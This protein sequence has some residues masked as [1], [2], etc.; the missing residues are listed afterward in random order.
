MA[1]TYRDTLSENRDKI[2]FRIGDTQ[3]NEGPRP[4][5]RNFS[6]AEV[7]FALSEEDSRVN[8]AIAHLFEILA[9]EWSAYAIA[10]REGELSM[11][12]KEAAAG[13]RT[14]ATIWRSKPGGASESERSTTL[15][16]LTR[17]DAYSD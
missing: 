1:F 6:D 7:A 14:Q 12:A 8:G 3:E 13:Y 9:A 11:D 16:T 17:E 5:R 10:E 15:I 2:R 4:D